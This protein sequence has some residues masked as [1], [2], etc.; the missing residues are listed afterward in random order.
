MKL[1]AFILLLSLYSTMSYS[2]LSKAEQSLARDFKP[3]MYVLKKDISLYH[4]YDSFKLTD[5]DYDPIKLIQWYRSAW[6]NHIPYDK[7]DFGIGLYAA[8]DPYD[9]SKYGNRLAKIT[10]NKGTIYLDVQ[11]LDRD[12]SFDEF[13][14]SNQTNKLLKKEG[15]K[16]SRKRRT[17]VKQEFS[18][19]KKCHTSLLKV[20]KALNIQFMLYRWGAGKNTNGYC[21]MSKKY[22]EYPAVLFTTYQVNYSNIEIIDYHDEHKRLINNDKSIINAELFGCAKNEYLDF[23]KLYNL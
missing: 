4:W 15:C 13:P 22:G 21:N 23:T 17:A 16:L 1:T 5:H 2:M 18:K 20:V 19:N 12:S 10:V 6:D 14:V 11:S 7:G 9:S 8:L 3:Y